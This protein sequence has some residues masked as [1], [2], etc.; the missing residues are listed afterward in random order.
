M[1]LVLINIM[2]LKNCKKKGN[3]F[4]HHRAQQ[5]NFLSLHCDFSLLMYNQ[6]E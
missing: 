2:M 5:L 1:F 6:A 3:S 4:I